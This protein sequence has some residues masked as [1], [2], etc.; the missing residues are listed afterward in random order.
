MES[1]EMKRAR[2][3]EYS[4]ALAL[5][6]EGRRHTDPPHLPAA[7]AVRRR[8]PAAQNVTTSTERAMDDA[9]VNLYATCLTHC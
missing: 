4:R 6:M 5:R 7:G 8:P 1:G 3:G 2:L 9:S